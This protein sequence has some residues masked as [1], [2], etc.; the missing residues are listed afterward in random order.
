MLAEESP[1]FLNVSTLFLL[2]TLRICFI[3][4]WKAAKGLLDLFT[5]S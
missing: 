3:M 2:Y 4:L 5:W 1:P